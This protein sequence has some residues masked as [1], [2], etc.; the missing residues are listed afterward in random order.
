MHW[1]RRAILRLLA[2]AIV[3]ALSAAGA[4]AVLGATGTA[5]AQPSRSVGSTL[6]WAMASSSLHNISA[7]NS[8]QASRDF[9][10]ANTVIQSSSPL[11]VDPV[12]SGW[13]SART[14][15]WAS[16]AQFAFDV[17][18][19]AVPSYVRVVHYDNEAWSETPL[20]EQLHPS[21]YEQKFC[22]LAHS[23]GWL[24][25]LGPA[26]DLCNVLAK[27]S[28]DNDAQCY[29]DLNLAGNA[30]RY[31][32]MIDI[33]A[34]TLEPEGANAYASFLRKAAA[35][36][37]AADPKVLVLGNISPTPNGHTVSAQQM[38]ACATAALP[39]VSGFYTTVE[40]G[41]GS[42]MVS[43]LQ[44]LDDRSS[45]RSPRDR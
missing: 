32:D 4:A 22:A 33:Q 28:G 29:L 26:Q 1:P 11:T 40:A 10:S 37:R 44:L 41:R 24:C 38:Y 36:A 23:H 5:S 30:A 43:F 42:T 34:Q 7:A 21:Y 17:H 6:H 13:S 16:Y 27:P 9:D 12:P 39:Y 15:R 14:D 18:R 2:A 25:Y 20:A 31:A 3:L 45:K 35:Q 19:G 8:A